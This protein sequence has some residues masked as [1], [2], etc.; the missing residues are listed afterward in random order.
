[1]CTFL[2]DYNLQGRYAGRITLNNL[3]WAYAILMKAF[4][5]IY[6]KN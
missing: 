4:M 5:H 3:K 1:M 2:A 6:L